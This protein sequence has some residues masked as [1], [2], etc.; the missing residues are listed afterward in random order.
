VT[1]LRPLSESELHLV[2]CDLCGSESAVTI[3]RRRG[4]VYD[5]TFS[6]VRCTNCRLVYVNPRLSDAA[7]SDLYDEAYYE[8][9]GFDRSV[10]YS[11]DNSRSLDE[12]R[13]RNGSFVETLRDALG[14][15]KGRSILDVG[16]GMGG[17]VRALCAEGADAVGTDD[18][19]IS[20][21]GCRANGTP[22]ASG[23]VEALVR[24]GSGFDAVTATEVIEHT[25]SPRAFLQ[26]VVRLVKPGG[27]LYLT[28]GN[29]NLVR[30]MR[31]KPYIMPEGHLYYF[32][33]VTMRRYFDDIGLVSARGLN[34]TWAF[35][36]ISPR[37][38][39]V[40]APL[41]AAV[42]GLIAPGYGPFPIA[43]RPGPG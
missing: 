7:V 41:G 10:D 9:R 43:R 26:S 31:G 8:G 17:F 29:W 33:P 22:L 35:Y 18:S 28:T 6:I 25:L 5:W 34:R 36:R 2:S 27:I 30:H 20:L 16:C 11:L 19:A 37:I 1:S 15:L 40:I 39:E 3:M 24:S 23:D 4:T 12:I 13:I 14:G 38:G 32:T 21:E 42:I